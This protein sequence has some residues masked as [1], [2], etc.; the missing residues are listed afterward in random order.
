MCVYVC[1]YIYIYITMRLKRTIL[2]WTSSP[3]NTSSV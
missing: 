1:V 3:T 2:N